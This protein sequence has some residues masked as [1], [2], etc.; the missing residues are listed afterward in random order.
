LAAG[1][2][3]ASFEL[4]LQLPAFEDIDIDDQQIT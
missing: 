4:P 3:D 1:A 2:G